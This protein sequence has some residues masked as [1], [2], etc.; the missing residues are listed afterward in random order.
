MYDLKE[1]F[2]IR[3][4]ILLRIE[5]EGKGSFVGTKMSSWRLRYHRKHLC[6]SYAKETETLHNVE[7]HVLK[8][9]KVYSIE[10][11]SQCFVMS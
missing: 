2:Y 11:Q 1:K 3:T 4:T 9:Y 6:L 10:G 8:L 5:F 7:G